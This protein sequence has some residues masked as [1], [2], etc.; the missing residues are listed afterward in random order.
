MEYVT[1]YTPVYRNKKTG[2]LL[3]TQHLLCSLGLRRV[4]SIFDWRKIKT[5]PIED[6]IVIYNGVQHT[7]SNLSVAIAKA[8]KTLGNLTVS[9]YNKDFCFE[10]K[11]C[12]EVKVIID[13]VFMSE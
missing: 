1:R 5:L 4:C 9:V 8:A 13:S 3:C 10:V 12:D 11:Y 7:R 2:E 6:R